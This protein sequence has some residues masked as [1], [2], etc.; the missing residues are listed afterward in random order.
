MCPM[1]YIDI[2]LQTA[3]PHVPVLHSDE[4][5]TGMAWHSERRTVLLLSVDQ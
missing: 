1:L 3:R 2:S 5:G 4:S